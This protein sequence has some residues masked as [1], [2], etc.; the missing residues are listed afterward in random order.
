[1]TWQEN[2][3]TNLNKI[4]CNTQNQ[5][6]T[7]A[8]SAFETCFWHVRITCYILKFAMQTHKSNPTRTSLFLHCYLEFETNNS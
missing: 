4:A 3:D 6:T 5:F 2:V 8:L 1:M 7:R